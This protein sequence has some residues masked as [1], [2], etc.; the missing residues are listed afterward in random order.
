MI[1]KFKKYILWWLLAIFTLA[2][3]N[4][5]F[6]LNIVNNFVYANGP[7]T[8]TSAS[9]WWQNQ[10]VEIP[11][12]TDSSIQNFVNLLQSVLQVF[13]V[14]LWPFIAIAW[15]SMDNSLIYWSVFHLDRP[16]FMFWNMMKNFANYFI[17]FVFIVSVLMYVFQFKEG[18]SLSVK[19][20]IP[21]LLL[22][23]ILIQASWWM[24]AALIDISTI[25]VYSI[26]AM[27]L[28]LLKNDKNIWDTIM[29][30]ENA[31]IDITSNSSTNQQKVKVTKVIDW[32]N[33]VSCAT[34]QSWD[35]V[36]VDQKWTEDLA[37]AAKAE[38]DN[39][40]YSS[41]VIKTSCPTELNRSDE[42]YKQCVVTNGI[43]LWELLSKAKGMTWPLYTL[44]W[45]LLN[46]SKLPVTANTK[47]LGAESMSAML[48]ALVWIALLL[49]LVALTI[50]LIIRVVL[51]WIFIWFSP[52][53]VAA[54]VFDFLPFTKKLNDWKIWLKKMVALI[55][56]PVGAVF[57]IWLSIIFLTLLN[58]P[59]ND[60][61]SGEGKLRIEKALDI[62]L[63]QAWCLKYPREW[64]WMKICQKTSKISYWL[65]PL[66]D[67]FGW[68]IINFFGIWLMWAIVFAAMKTWWVTDKVVDGVQWF[69][70]WLLKSAPIIPTPWWRQSVWSLWIAKDAVKRIPWQIASKQFDDV[71]QP[72]IKE[73]EKAF[74]LGN[75]DD[76]ASS[77]S[78]STTWWNPEFAQKMT[79]FLDKWNVSQNNDALSYINKT[80]NKNYTK[81]DD[82]YQDPAF[83]DMARSNWIEPQKLAQMYQSTWNSAKDLIQWA[84][85]LKQWLGKQ[86]HKEWDIEYH[87]SNDDKFAFAHNTKTWHIKSYFIWNSTT[88]ENDMKQIV[89]LASNVKV[90]NMGKFISWFKDWKEF[91]K[92]VIKI[93]WDVC[94]YEPK[95]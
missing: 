16:L 78:G 54:F 53:I 12:A 59:S 26:W 50:V 3:L 65:D 35:S 64:E 30:W 70:Q 94:T 61:Q 19:K 44:Y 14:I 75:K 73:L 4:N 56:M 36:K 52:I 32:K 18:T 15:A 93:S 49:P 74:G 85:K 21:K 38:S 28:N 11:T 63:S 67:I 68:L 66:L 71:L 60:M 91:G 10:S 2:F 23:W 45:S 1:S 7:L 46:Y 40:V 24:T 9:A 5:H 39:C 25:A 31:E 33:Y 69:G 17:W 57:A 27:P 41:W 43:K 89:E 80:M 77:S 86:V 42:F 79:E 51:L 29:T 58:Q 20:I 95:K 88:N 22:W 62:D 84:E 37:N 81:L 13:Y 48:K 6:W 72:K 76:S 82:A 92:Y 34:K 47:S 8:S 83:I 87:K 90:A 55:F